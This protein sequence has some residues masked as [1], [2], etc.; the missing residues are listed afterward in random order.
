MRL[1]RFFAALLVWLALAPTAGAAPMNFGDRRVNITAREQPVAEFMRDL[2]GLLDVPVV[3]SPAVKGAVSGSFN[4]PAEKVLRN[5]S[6]AFG[7]AM[8]FDGSVMYVYTA[9]E[10][11]TRTLMLPSATA[12]NKVKRLAAEMGLTDARNYLR[13]RPTRSSVWPPRWGSP[14]RATTCARRPMAW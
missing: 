10:T 2:F 12:A 14:T 1:A 7:L 9:G 8:Y 4:G 6:N 13:T 11:A 5:V 3:V